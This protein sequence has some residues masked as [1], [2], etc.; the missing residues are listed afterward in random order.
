MGGGRF[1]SC[2]R[3][4]GS[5]NHPPRHPH[6]AYVDVDRHPTIEHGNGVPDSGVEPPTEHVGRA[7]HR[8][9]HLNLDDD[10]VRAGTREG[11]RLA[12][13]SL[14]FRRRAHVAPLSVSGVWTG[15]L[16]TSGKRGP[17]DRTAKLPAAAA[18][19]A[20]RTLAVAPTKMPSGGR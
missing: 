11:D 13:W 15:V 19:L 7:L 2:L 14:R 5:P 10:A 4:P 18:R 20:L 9:T 8:P 12:A 3:R 17:T 16:G 6:L 1:E